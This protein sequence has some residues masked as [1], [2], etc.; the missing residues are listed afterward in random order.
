M[1]SRSELKELKTLLYAKV[2]ECICQQRIQ[3]ICKKD[4]L[5]SLYKKDAEKFKQLLKKC[6][7]TL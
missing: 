5:V 7:E 6:E 1:F 3:E 2:Q 4:S